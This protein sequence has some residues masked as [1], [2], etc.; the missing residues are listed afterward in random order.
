MLLVD[1]ASC[2]SAVRRLLQCES[3][4]FLSRT[5]DFRF[6]LRGCQSEDEDDAGMID[7][8]IFTDDSPV[9]RAACDSLCTDAESDDPDLFVVDE[10]YVDV[11]RPKTVREFMD[12]VNQVYNYAVCRCATHFIKDNAAVCIPCELSQ[13]SGAFSIE[14]PICTDAVTR[15]RW[16]RK[17]ERC[18]KSLCA[19][20]FA[21]CNN[22]CPLCKHRNSKFLCV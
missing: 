1:E 22:V 17:C 2:R 11:K 12:Q 18:E 8:C 14:C 6:V 10:L 20:C 21:K 3:A 13:D 19:M 16:A 5:G 4:T 9:L 15:K 7:I